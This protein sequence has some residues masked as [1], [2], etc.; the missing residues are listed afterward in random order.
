MIPQLLLYKILQLFIIMLLGFILV[1]TGIV[2]SKDSL[3]LSKLSLYVFMPAVIINSFSI[4]FSDDVINGLMLA[5]IIAFLIHIILFIID[6]TIKRFFKAMCVERASV[7]YSNAG[8][9]IIPI[10]A[11]VFGEE[12]V[13]YSSAYLI[14][15]LVFL[16]T[17]GVRLFSENEKFHIK[18]ILLNVNIIAVFVGFI[19]M[20]S[21]I[22]FPAFTKDIFS[23]L[24]GMMAPTGMIVSG[25]LAAEINFKKA[26]KNKRLY[27]VTFLRLIACPII[28]MLFLKVFLMFAEVN[29]ASNI[30]LI[31]YLASITPS[32]STITQFAQIYE[33]DAEYSV[34]INAVTTILGVITMPLAIMLL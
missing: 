20:I 26:L 33:K 27:F 3:I 23:S 9:L 34:V 6:L 25:M 19:V 5:F 16:W 22:K 14:V 28:I 8:N 17:H 13:V 21:G 18:K 32:A 7:M 24:G 10:V 30:M 4:D 11:F 2:K 1:K 29:N 12:W 15:Q 31:A